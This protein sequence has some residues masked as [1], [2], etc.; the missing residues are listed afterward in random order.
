[1]RAEVAQVLAEPRL[2]Q[3]WEMYSAAFA[4]LRAAAAQRHV[5]N[6]VE[7]RQVMRD[8]RV[9]K[10]LA[11]SDD[12]DRIAALATFTNDL[13]AMPLISPEFFAR[14]WPKLYAQRRV[15]Y[16]GFFAIE[17]SSR[18]SGVFEQVITRMWA[19][20]QEYGGVAAL[21]VCGQNAELGLPFAIRRVLESL[22][23]QVIAEQVDVQ[24]YWA[25]SLK[26]SG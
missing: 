8:T 11:A 17:P 3:A 10:H 13:E 21:D 4:D 5:M 16:L 20:V 14:R 12:G 26:P 18:G 25:F 22:T 7:F 2:T 1:M 9:G 23:P 19:E 6:E 24:A 15:W